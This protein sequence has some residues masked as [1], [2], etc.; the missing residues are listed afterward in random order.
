MRSVVEQPIPDA[1]SVHQ[2]KP[3]LHEAC[4]FVYLLAYSTESVLFI[5]S[6]SQLVVLEHEE[7]EDIAN[8]LCVVHQ[9]PPDS[10]AMVISVD[11]EPPDFIPYQRNKADHDSVLLEHPRFGVWQIDLADVVPFPFEECIVEK[12]MG[13]RARSRCRTAAC[14]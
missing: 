14:R 1:M 13:A 8:A 10:P 5:E 3:Q 11:E 9:R 7:L 12:R 6:S 4:F 2:P